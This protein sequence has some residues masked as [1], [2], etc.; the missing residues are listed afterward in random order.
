MKRA[1]QHTVEKGFVPGCIVSVVSNV[2]GIL[3]EVFLLLEPSLEVP[4]S[5]QRSV[6]ASFFS[7]KAFREILE[8][9]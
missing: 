8:P 1:T 4:V 5:P 7:R 9:Q 6:T 3:K 2:S